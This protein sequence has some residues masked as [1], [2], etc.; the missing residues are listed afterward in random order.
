MPMRDWCA[1]IFLIALLSC[2]CL[3]VGCEKGPAMYKVSGKVKLKDGSIPKAS[4]CLVNFTP[5]K[6]SKAEVRRNATGAIGPD[7][8]FTMNTRLP[9]DG[10]HAGEYSVVFNVAKNPMAPVSL[11]LPKYTDVHSPPYTVKVDHDI[12][13]LDYTIEALPG[14]GL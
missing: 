11:L 14:A 2:L 12:N 3:A 6:D 5:T 8:S 1:K 4:V 10:V 7:G 13:D 9:D